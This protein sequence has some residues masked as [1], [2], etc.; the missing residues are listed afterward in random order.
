[1]CADVVLFVSCGSQFAVGRRYYII[2]HTLKI[3]IVGQALDTLRTD[4][5]KFKAFAEMT[6]HMSEMMRIDV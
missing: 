1:M 3:Y 2:I 4:P 5:Q 6:R